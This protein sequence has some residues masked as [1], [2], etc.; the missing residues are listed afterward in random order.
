MKNRMIYPALLLS[1][2]VLFT[3]CRAKSDVSSVQGVAGVVE[4][5]AVDTVAA[6]KDVPVL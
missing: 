1:V 6:E 3:Q 2:C 5:A 4:T